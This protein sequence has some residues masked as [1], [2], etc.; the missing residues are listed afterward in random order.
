MPMP[1]GPKTRR[2]GPSWKLLDASF[3]EL[4]R[5]ALVHGLYT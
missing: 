1:S 5:D 4:R 2:C 3:D